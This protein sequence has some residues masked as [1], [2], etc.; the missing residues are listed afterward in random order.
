MKNDALEYIHVSH[1]SRRRHS[2]LNELEND[3]LIFLRCLMRKG[4]CEAEL[5]DSQNE[6]TR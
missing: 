2:Y 5:C 3:E 6:I 4:N 1:I